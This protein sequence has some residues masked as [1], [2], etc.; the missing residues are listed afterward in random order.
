MMIQMRTS[1]GSYCVSVLYEYETVIIP[2]AVD[3]GQVIGL[4]YKSDGLYM[5]SEGSQSDS[6]INL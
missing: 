3:P 6:R 2:Q 4:D 1:D 5:D